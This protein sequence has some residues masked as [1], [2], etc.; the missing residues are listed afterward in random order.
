[1]ESWTRLDDAPADAARQLLA[2][3]CGSDRWVERMLARRPFGSLEELLSSARREWF[4]LDPADWREAFAHHPRIG[5]RADLQR[6]FATARE[7][8]EREQSGVAGAPDEIL[9]A[10]ADANRS[11][12]ERFGYI[13]IVR[14][15][16]RTAAQMLE[17]L[18]ERLANPPE[19]EIEVAATEQA[20]ITELRLLKLG[21]A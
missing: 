12:E 3:C 11:Y 4:A 13:F 20:K 2:T 21:A 16:G 7:L 10:L 9:D 17:L 14:A 1:M 18:R 5:N 6:R 15:T 19:I 8:S